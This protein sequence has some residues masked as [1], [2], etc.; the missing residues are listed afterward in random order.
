[1][2]GNNIVDSSRR[3]PTST[4]S[5][6]HHRLSPYSHRT[7]SRWSPPICP[8][9]CTSSRHRIPYNLPSMDKEQKSLTASW[10]DRAK[11]SWR[12][13]RKSSPSVPGSSFQA[14]MSRTPSPSLSTGSSID[15]S[16]P[17]KAKINLPSSSTISRYAGRPPWLPASSFFSTQRTSSPTLSDISS[18]P[19]SPPSVNIFGTGSPRPTAASSPVSSTHYQNSPQSAPQ[20][21]R[22]DPNTSTG[23]IDDS[24]KSVRNGTRESSTGATGATGDSGGWQPPGQPHGSVQTDDSSAGLVW[25]NISRSSLTPTF[26]STP[27]SSSDSIKLSLQF[28]LEK[29]SKQQLFQTCVINS[30]NILQIRRILESNSDTFAALS[31]IP[32]VHSLIEPALA[33]SFIT[34][35]QNLQSYNFSMFFRLHHPPPSFPSLHILEDFNKMLE[36]IK[37]KNDNNSVQ[38]ENFRDIPVHISQIEQPEK[39]PIFEELQD[40]LYSTNLLNPEAAEFIPSVNLPDDSVLPLPDESFI[41]KTTPS[42]L[43]KMELDRASLDALLDSV[44]LSPIRSGPATPSSSTID[45]LLGDSPV[46]TSPMDT[47]S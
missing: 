44:G 33:P 32:L 12:N 31:Q 2:F 3:N 41:S 35:L 8:T 4:P 45:A 40:A 10:A 1:M 21:P 16:P 5:Q 36:E 34:P 30:L 23:P 19:L 46:Q 27:D 24:T 15:Y 25:V 22:H 11:T 39:D 13:N 9:E 6:H 26:S 7:D 42:D 18:T 14:G 20:W 38:I 17:D 47:S 29:I 43:G 37:K 28:N